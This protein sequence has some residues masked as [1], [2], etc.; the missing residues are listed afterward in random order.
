LSKF[1]QHHA[2]FALSLSIL[3]NSWALSTNSGSEPA[4]A[5]LLG[6]QFGGRGDKA[7]E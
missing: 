6:A 1:V 2:A 3:W 4:K 5:D 7:N